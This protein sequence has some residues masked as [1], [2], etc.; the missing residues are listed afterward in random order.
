MFG[1]TSE[2]PPGDGGQGGVCRA[3]SRLGARIVYGLR[4][5]A[6]NQSLQVP[7]L[8]GA[9]FRSWDFTHELGRPIR[10]R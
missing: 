7:L 3:R 2:V 1:H 9:G 10:L 8:Y 4:D 5:S 6:I